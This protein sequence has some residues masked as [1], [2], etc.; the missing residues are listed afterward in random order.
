ML[1]TTYRITG[2]IIIGT[3]IRTIIGTTTG[4]TG[5]G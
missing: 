2:I 4:G 5:A 1:L 3:T